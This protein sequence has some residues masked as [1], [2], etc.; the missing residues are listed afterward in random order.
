MAALALFAYALLLVLIVAPV[1]RHCRVFDRAPNLG[2]FAWQVVVTS[3]LLSVVLGCLVLLVPAMPVASNLA[4]FLE[5][6]VMIIQQRYA[7]PAGALL[8]GIGVAVAAVILIRTTHHLARAMANG[9]R[10]RRAHSEVLALAGRRGPGDI[11]VLEHSA[12]AAYCLPGRGRRIVLT[13]GALAALSTDQL[14]AVLAHERAHL[15]S[16]H[17]LVLVCAGAIADAFS[18]V[19][20]FQT[21][22]AEISR[23][24]ELA[25]DDAAVRATSRFA[26]AEALL[27]LAE[28]RSP[29][30]ALAA[31]GSTAAARVRRLLTSHP[32]LPLLPILAGTV[33]ALSLLLLPMALAAGPAV[34]VISAEYCPTGPVPWKAQVAALLG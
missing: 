24:V 30:A 2:I 3:A 27:A 11:M 10:Q 17:H 32:P 9:R 21:A 4:D 6:C 19:R 15:R 7:S 23:L 31:G 20:A 5:A 34:S 25:A 26:L 12:P 13:S 33:L 16:R 28:S 14:R 8:A 18:Y 29:S 1:M 22:H